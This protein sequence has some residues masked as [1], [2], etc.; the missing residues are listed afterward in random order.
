MHAV[1]R[2]LPTPLAP[3]PYLDGAQSD[4]EPV[5]SLI[6]GGVSPGMLNYC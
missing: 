2:V 3:N 6:P 4:L 1:V 5:D